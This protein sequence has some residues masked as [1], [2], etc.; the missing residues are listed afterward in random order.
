MI[1]DTYMPLHWLGKVLPDG[2]KGPTDN[3]LCCC[4]LFHK[5]T[6]ED[7]AKDS[8]IDNALRKE[9][10]MSGAINSEAIGRDTF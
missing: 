9:I 6:C 5:D 4:N 1:V 3:L 10:P 7:E 8:L 2:S